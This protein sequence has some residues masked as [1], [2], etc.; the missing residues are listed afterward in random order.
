MHKDIMTALVPNKLSNIQALRGIAA[1]LVVFTHLPAMEMKH[2][3]EQI[4]PAFTRFGISGVDLF[5]VISGFIMVYVTWE[6]SRNIKNSLKFLFARITRIYP[7]YWVIALLV[8]GAWIVRPSLISF[9][10][11]KTSLIKSFLLWPDQTLPMLKVAWTLVHELYFYLVFALILLFPRKLLLPALCAWTALVV[12]G[13]Q[14][15]WGRLSPET[16]LMTHPLS[17]EFFLGAVAG[18]VY[19]K[20]NA[21]GGWPVFLVG[22]FLFIVGLYYLATAFSVNMYPT[23]WER[24]LYFGVPAVLIV[25]G[26]ASMEAKGFQLPRWS[27]RLGDWSYSL[28]LSHI[29]SLSV[30]GL[31]WRS[32][33]RPGMI[34]NVIAI[35]VMLIGS[36]FVAAVFW[37]I[38][39]KPAL[40]FFKSL[41]VKLFPP[42]APQAPNGI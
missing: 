31:F 24:V 32:F 16:A 4:L 33:A 10:P 27:S 14:M 38:V 18:W 17:V 26:L 23:N 7:I 5:F 36:I 40:T 37:Y 6:Q 2:G 39:E 25:Y 1:L 3:G 30:L 15:G 42:Q 8:L 9:D 19:K 11:A 29:L 22:L 28:Y 13:D 12:L 20:F 41:R 21:F 35:C 34:D